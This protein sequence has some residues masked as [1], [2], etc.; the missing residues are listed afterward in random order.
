[1]ITLSSGEVINP[2]P[3]EERL[4]SHIPL[5]R[6]A[7][8]VGQNAPFLCALLTLKVPRAP[9]NKTGSLQRLGSMGVGPSLSHCF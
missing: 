9:R 3:I 4:R 8:V 5:V 6:Y 1:M 7:M 2:C